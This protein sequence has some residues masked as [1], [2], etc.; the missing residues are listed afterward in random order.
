MTPKTPL[1]LETAETERDRLAAAAR[2]AG[3]LADALA[4]ERRAVLDTKRRAWSATVL[5]DHSTIAAGLAKAERDAR[6]AFGRAAVHG[7]PRESFLSWCDRRVE[8][9][10]F[11]D[12]VGAARAAIGE[13]EADGSYV[14]RD[15]PSYSAELDRALSAEA[16][17]RWLDAQAALQADLNQLDQL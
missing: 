4:S 7:D 14:F 5:K 12:R 17:S 1:T 8:A 10:L 2:A 6:A 15:V 13:P 9:N 3:D 16:S 11:R